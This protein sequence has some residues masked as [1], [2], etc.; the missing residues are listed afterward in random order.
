[1]SAS[2]KQKLGDGGPETGA[3][4][5]NAQVPTKCLRTAPLD[6]CEL[7]SLL[8]IAEAHARD[9]DTVSD[10]FLSRSSHNTGT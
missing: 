5:E 3:D 1:M 8:T 6:D 4:G 7:N 9:S 2:A 10:S